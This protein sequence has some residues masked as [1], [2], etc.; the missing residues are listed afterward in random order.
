MRGVTILDLFIEWK[1]KLRKNNIEY[2]KLD[3]ECANIRTS[4]REIR[5]TIYF[6][7]NKCKT[8]TLLRI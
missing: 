8:N 6:V 2:L 5:K 4:V 7:V 1:I 3:F